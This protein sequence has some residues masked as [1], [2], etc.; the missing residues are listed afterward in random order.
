MVGSACAYPTPR[1]A[2]NPLNPIRDGDWGLQLFPM[3]EEFPVSAGHKLAL[4]KSLPFVH[5]ARRYYRSD[6]LVRSSDGPPAG[7]PRGPWRS[8]EKSIKL[9]YLEEDTL[10]IDISNAHCGPGSIPGLRLSEGRY[11]YLSDLPSQAGPR[12]EVRTWS[13]APEKEASV[14]AGGFS[15]LWLPTFSLLFSPPAQADHGKV[16]VL[17]RYVRERRE[18]VVTCVPPPPPVGCGGGRGSGG[19]AS[20]VFLTGRPVRGTSVTSRPVS[21]LA[22]VKRDSSPNPAVFT[23]L[24]NPPERTRERPQIR[25]DNP[26]NLSIL[27]SGGKETNKD[28]LSSGERRGKSPAL[29]PPSG[30]GRGEL[31]RME[32]ARGIQPGGEAVPVA[33]VCSASKPPAFPLRGVASGA[34]GPPRGAGLGRRRAHFL[35]GGAPRPA[36]VRLG[37]VRGRRWLVSSGLELYSALPPRLRRLPPGAAGEYLRAFLPLRGPRTGPPPLP[38]RLSTGPDCPQSVA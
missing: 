19:S 32:S 15:P 36:P 33:R 21:S 22:R 31:W 3:N 4:I 7:A 1:G 17:F 5:T 34:A 13:P 25:R 6:G 35:R 28:S 2:G 23:L 12:L 11:S 38:T 10:I 8:A 30:C 16:S 9:D 37:R 20:G 14:A 26:L 29:N 24:G 27:L 18:V